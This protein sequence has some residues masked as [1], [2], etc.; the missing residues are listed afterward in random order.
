MQ[1][2]KNGTGKT[3]FA[4]NALADSYSTFK[5]NVRKLTTLAVSSMEE[6]SVPHAIK[7]MSSTV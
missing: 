6:D 4:L 7:D 3:K 5:E 1:A 2:V